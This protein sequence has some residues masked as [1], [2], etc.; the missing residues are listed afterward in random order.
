MSHRV[1]RHGAVA[2]A[3]SRALA[4]LVVASVLAAAC[5]DAPQGDL[6]TSAD[7]CASAPV[8][9]AGF[10]V[11]GGWKGIA[12]PPT[13]RF[14][15][16]QVDGV[17]WLVTPEGHGMF[18]N[19]VTG[20]DPEGDVTAA[21]ADPYRDNI[22]ARYGSV[23][24]WA[25]STLQ[26]MCDL[27]VATLAGWTNS[28]IYLFA[29]KR[30]YP[31]S[32][33]FYDTAPEVP[34]WPVGLTGEHLRDVFDP[35]W[36]DAARRY[37]HA[38]Q[39]LAGCAADAWCYGAFVD[40]ELPWGAT[41]LSVGTHLDAYLSEPAG[42]PGKLAVQR[43]FAERYGG[44]VAAFAA[45]WNL[46]LGSFDDLQQL[47]RA[48]ACPLVEPLGEDTCL[49]AEP[50]TVRADRM[51][52]EAVV[53]E[54][55]AAVMSAALREAAPD[56]LNLGVRFFSIYTH[57]D[58]VRAVAPYVDVMSVNDYDY[59]AVERPA[60][61]NL[62]GGPEFGYLFA[63]D[64]FTDLATLYQLSGKPVLIGEWFYR[65]H[66]TDGASGALPPLF[67][68]VETH[69]EQGAAYRAYAERVI[70]LPYVIGHHWFQWM[71]QPFEGRAAGGENQWIGVVDI[72][73]DLRVP[74]ADAMREVNGALIER[75]AELAEPAR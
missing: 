42:S 59:G 32:L 53:A 6:A 74:L 8:R 28:A 39:P 61:T 24:A 16:A 13:G 17:W 12:L 73:D 2:R 14:R 7:V 62:S 45:A 49:K 9:G 23:E 31:V 15:V 72:H 65:V 40:N 36:P 25:A 37:A 3:A 21:G 70:A 63:S 11:Y 27:G 56:V 43:F 71:D 52:F 34:G 18:T 51:A 26:R 38:S 41:T 4:A 54:R 58:V 67:P 29:G 35:S 22:L 5:S 66:R 75:R 69:E 48:T 46:D 68:Q 30:A 64:A 1:G 44:D 33:A 19:G 57:P 47:T 50:A 55:Y 20:I 60:L 10:D